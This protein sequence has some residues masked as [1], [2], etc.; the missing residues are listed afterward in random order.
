MGGG[1]GE[2]FFLFHYVNVLHYI[3]AT[4]VPK[5]NYI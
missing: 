3:L 2:C 5:N 1:G 4:I